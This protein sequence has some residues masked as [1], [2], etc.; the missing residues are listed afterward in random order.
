ML[1]RW[2]H[3]IERRMSRRTLAQVMRVVF[4]LSLIPLVVIALYNYPADDD[5]VNA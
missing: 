3:V 1:K 4:F 5:F 2:L